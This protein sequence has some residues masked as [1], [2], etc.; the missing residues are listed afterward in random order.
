MLLPCQYSCS[1][2]VSGRGR[3]ALQ[4]LTQPHVVWQKPWIRGESVFVLQLSNNK[5][6]H[7]ATIQYW[8]CRRHAATNSRPTLQPVLRR[9][10]SPQTRMIL[11]DCADYDLVAASFVSNCALLCGQGALCCLKGCR[12]I[13]TKLIMLW[14]NLPG[15]EICLWRP[16]I[17]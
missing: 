2:L 11:N 3:R 1:L 12:G 10:K 5:K 16:M 15:T 17:A 14:L 6:S 7:H 9:R 8:T 4:C 13:N